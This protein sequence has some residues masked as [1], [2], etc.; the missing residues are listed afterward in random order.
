MSWLILAKS[1]F[2]DPYSVGVHRASI[3]RFFDAR[4]GNVHYAIC[5]IVAKRERESE[6]FVIKILLQKSL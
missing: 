3:M 4:L 6:N 1:I 2:D 5:R